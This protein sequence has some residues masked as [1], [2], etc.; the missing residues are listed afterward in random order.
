MTCE[1]GIVQFAH[2]VIELVGPD[3]THKLAGQCVT[4]VHQVQ[5][6]TRRSID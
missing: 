4:E 1:Q 2:P 6:Q 5:W 3:G